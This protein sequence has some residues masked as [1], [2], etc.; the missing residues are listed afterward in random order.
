[1]LF[2]L[3]DLL[4]ADGILIDGYNV[5]CDESS[6]TGESNTIEKV[7]CSLSLSSTSS[8][9][10]FDERYDPFM[11][12]GSK[13]VEGTGKCIVTSVG[14]HSYYEKIM[15]SIQTESDDT[16]LQIKLSKFALGIAKFGIL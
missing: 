16:P 15:T 13:I 5:S 12:S 9:L 8:K 4:S 3:G 2:E 11:I 7:P 6:A 1:M 14:I 10:I